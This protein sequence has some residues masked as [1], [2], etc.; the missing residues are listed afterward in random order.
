[1]QSRFFVGYGLCFVLLFGDGML[2][3]GQLRLRWMMAWKGGD[4]DQTLLLHLRQRNLRTKFYR[5]AMVLLLVG[6]SGYLLSLVF[7]LSVE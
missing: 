2:V 1:M 7:Y 3:V 6:L 5:V 4:I